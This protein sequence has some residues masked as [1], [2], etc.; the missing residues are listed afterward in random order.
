MTSGC[1]TLS[2]KGTTY[3]CYY[4]SPQ[5]FIGF[6]LYIPPCRWEQ[7]R[8]HQSNEDQTRDIKPMVGIGHAAQNPRVTMITLTIIFLVLMNQMTLVFQH[9]FIDIKE[10]YACF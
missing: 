8:S 7:R 10:Q 1:E 4:A 9:S 6:I 5:S 3:F 2:I